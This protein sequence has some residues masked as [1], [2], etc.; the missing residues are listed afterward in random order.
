[1]RVF[2]KL[3]LMFLS[4]SGINYHLYKALKMPSLANI[5]GTVK[6]KLQIMYKM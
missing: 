4:S 5:K 1:M 3:Y 6:L 2:S